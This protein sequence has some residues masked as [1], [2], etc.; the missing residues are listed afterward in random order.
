MKL[1]LLKEPKGCKGSTQKLPITQNLKKINFWHF[2]FCSF[3]SCLYWENKPAIASG[4][5]PTEIAAGILVKL[6]NMSFENVKHF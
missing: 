5:Y 6:C 1:K 4:V 2:V 3:K